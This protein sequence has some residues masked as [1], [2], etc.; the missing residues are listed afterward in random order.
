M[1][2]E[3][4]KKTVIDFSRLNTEQNIISELS[5]K[6]CL[7]YSEESEKLESLLK[8]YDFSIKVMGM[9]RA[10]DNKEFTYTVNVSV[11]N[12]VIK[13]EINF[14]FHMS[15]HDSTI[16]EFLLKSNKTREDYKKVYDMMYP[17][18]NNKSFMDSFYSHIGPAKMGRTFKTKK[19]DID[20]SMLYSILCCIHMDYY[21]PDTF[22][23][24]CSEFGYDE[25]S[26]KAEKTY[27]SCLKQS[28]KLK[29]VFSEDCID[30]LPS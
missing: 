6:K 17:Y 4:K 11:Y 8:D 16:I 21:T 25:D 23:E 14:E 24:F 1:N 7:E 18:S 26:R 20:N 9:E 12:K 29:T 10:F 30:Y 15:I 2:T 5:L 27:L 3:L 19:I 28:K 22:E 13:K